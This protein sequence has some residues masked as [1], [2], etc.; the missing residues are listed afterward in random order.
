MKTKSDIK[1]V[2]G[3]EVKVLSLLSVNLNRKM[4]TNLYRHPKHKISRK[5][6]Q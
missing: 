1:M 6:F 2:A 4:S 5:F 3:L